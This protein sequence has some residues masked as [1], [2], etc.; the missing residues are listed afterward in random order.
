MGDELRNGRRGDVVDEREGWKE[1]YGR[2]S[3]W[4]MVMLPVCWDWQVGG[5]KPKFLYYYMVRILHS[6]LMRWPGSA[7]TICGLFPVF[8]NCLHNASFFI[9]NVSHP[10]RL[11]CCDNHVCGPSIDVAVQLIALLDFEA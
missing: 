11:A 4:G 7:Y 10:V 5:G 9:L 3:G 8:P 6:V 2:W 1:E